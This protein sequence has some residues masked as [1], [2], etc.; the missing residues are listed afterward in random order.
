MTKI[1]RTIV[2]ISLLLTAVSCR[3]KSVELTPSDG[4][5]IGV[6]YNDINRNGIYDTGKDK[7]L[8]NVRV[9]N[10][11]DITITDKNGVYELPLRENATIFVV[12]PSGYAFPLISNLSFIA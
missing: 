12:K 8:K 6:V 10:G 9:S 5:V 7:P 11:L 3:N 2:V 4:M 1:I